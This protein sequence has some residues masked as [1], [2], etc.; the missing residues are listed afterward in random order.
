MPTPSDSTPT[1]PTPTDTEILQAIRAG[2]PSAFDAFV[3]R[4]GRRLFAFGLRMCGHHEDAEDV[5]QETLLRAYEG[6][7][8]IRDPEAVRTWLFRVAANQ[9]L[10]KRRKEKPER[11]VSL[12][13]LEISP[14]RPGRLPED[15]VRHVVAAS[16]LPDDE[17]ARAELRAVVDAALLEVPKALRIVLLLRD[18][19]GLSTRETAEI[20]GIGDSAVKM[21][22]LR[23]RRQLRELL[24]DEA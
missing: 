6:L 21:R 12:D 22:L 16:E 7:E 14:D 18:V 20:L 4:Y 9:C 19:E 5:F 10:M 1:S 17:A 3:G 15:L 8:T 13:S 23:G 24:G 2:D 11:C